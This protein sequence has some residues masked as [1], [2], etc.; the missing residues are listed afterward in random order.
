MA[1]AG[2]IRVGVDATQES[3]PLGYKW[4]K[5]GEITTNVRN[6]TIVTPKWKV[7]PMTKEEQTERKATLAVGIAL[8][9]YL[10]WRI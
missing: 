2:D 6:G 1:E 9:T 10:L 8:V 7:V 4:E 3:V 5:I